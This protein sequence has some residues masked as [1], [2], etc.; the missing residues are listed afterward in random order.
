MRDSDQTPDE[1]TVSD[2]AAPLP[3]ASGRHP[4]ATLTVLTGL[5]AGLSLTLARGVSVV[6]RSSGV[7]VTLDDDSVSRR[8]C[9]IE[10]PVRGDPRLTD[11]G[12]TNGTVVNGKRVPRE[13]VYLREGDKVQLSST[14]V[15]KFGWKD[16]LEEAVQR[17]LYH[18][19]VRDALT[20]TYNKRYFMDRLLTEFSWACRNN[21]PL[22]CLVFDLDHFKRVND[23]WGH[24]A[25]DA[26]LRSV[27]ARMQRLVRSEDIFCRF[28][29]EEFVLLMRETPSA[30]AKDVGNRIRQFIAVS[31]ILWERNQI[32]VT[33]SAGLAASDEPGLESGHDLFMLADSRLYDAKERGRNQLVGS[34]D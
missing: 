20:G 5:N 18:S 26:V 8:H 4:R 28:G 34:E 10:V 17:R 30:H 24:A 15:L 14:V 9:Q 7:S 31:P 29:G 3:V 19:A 2:G 33:L 32:S 22:S 12:S 21:R 6:G 23:A 13:G 16:D 27:A 1:S 11:M 25:G